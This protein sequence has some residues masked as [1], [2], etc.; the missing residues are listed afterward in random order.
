MIEEQSLDV[1]NRRLLLRLIGIVA[2]MTT[3][4]FALIPLYDIFCEVTGINGKTGGKT[5][6]SETMQVDA[7]RTVSLG[8]IAMNSENIEAD[9]KPKVSQMLINPGKIYE[10]EFYVK[11][12]TNTPVILQAVPSVA[13]GQVAVFLHKTECFCFNQQPLKPGEAKW[14]PLQFFLDTEFPQENK[15]LTLQYTLYDIST[16]ANKSSAELVS[17]Q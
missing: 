12:N 16:A 10:T 15:E 6:A 4:A 14:L 2:L 9:F 8:F 11:N 5:A 13:P 7:S 1:K 17:T 3:F